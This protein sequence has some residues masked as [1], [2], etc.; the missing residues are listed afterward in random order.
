[1]NPYTK[2]ELVVIA[3]IRHRHTDY[4][5]FLRTGYTRE[6]ARRE[7]APE[8]LKTLSEWKG[9]SG[10]EEWETEFKVLI[11]LTEDLEDSDE[12]SPMPITNNASPVVPS[13]EPIPPPP[14]T[15]ATPTVPPRLPPPPPGYRLNIKPLPPGATVVDLCGSSPLRGGGDDNARQP[16]WMRSPKF[17]WLPHPVPQGRIALRRLSPPTAT[18]SRP[19]PPRANLAHLPP[20][21]PNMAWRRLSADQGHGGYMPAPKLGAPP[22]PPPPSGPGWVRYG[23]G[24]PA[25]AR[26]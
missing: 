12:Y 26:Y 17:E 21:P 8:L 2:I 7:C 25:P 18:D 5:M 10:A 23:G 22:P 14:R 9:E 19:S 11:D 24:S 13:V 15:L 6:D 20:P 3:H 4:D 1:M 16:E